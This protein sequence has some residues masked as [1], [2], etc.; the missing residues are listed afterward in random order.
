MYTVCNGFQISRESRDN[1]G[2]LMT[3]G[4]VI[5]KFKYCL[6]LLVMGGHKHID[7]TNCIMSFAAMSMSFS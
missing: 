1:S 3:W 6:G 2:L 5:L 7:T 4:Y